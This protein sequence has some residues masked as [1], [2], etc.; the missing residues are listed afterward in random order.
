MQSLNFDSYINSKYLSVQ[1]SKLKLKIGN[2]NFDG[3][4]SVLI[5]HLRFWKDSLS[6][7]DLFTQRHQELKD[8]A[9]FNSSA[10]LVN[11]PLTE[12]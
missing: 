2:G 1:P 7:D 12:G 4:G 5:K 8:S 10:L 6:S 9:R 3:E 11:A